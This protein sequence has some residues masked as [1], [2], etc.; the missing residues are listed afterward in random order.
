MG[1]LDKRIRRL[2]EEAGFS[3]RAKQAERERVLRE[4]LKLVCTP[5]LNAMQEALER[6]NR[7]EWAEED[8]P[9]MRRLLALM[10]EVRAEEARD[11]H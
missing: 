9:L 5:E 11:E 10:E 3:E 1:G 6:G 7:G 4:A 2:E 8:E